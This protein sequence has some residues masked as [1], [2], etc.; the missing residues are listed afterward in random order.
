L[1]EQID[2]V[3]KEIEGPNKAEKIFAKLKE[4]LKE[5]KEKVF[6]EKSDTKK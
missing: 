4:S 2:T 1:H 6:S 3:K 5:F